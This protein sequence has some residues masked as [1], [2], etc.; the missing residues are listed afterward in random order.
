MIKLMEDV[1]APLTVVAVDLITEATRPTWNQWAA[2]TM[3]GGGYLA[4]IL[5]LR[6]P[7]SDAF[8]KNIGIAALPWAAKHIYSRVRGVGSPVSRRLSMR[9]S[10]WPAPLVEEPFGGARLV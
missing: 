3:A 6:L 7:M 10:R 5:G 8:V 2:Y 9:V 1:G 4:D